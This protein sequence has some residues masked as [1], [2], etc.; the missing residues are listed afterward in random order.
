M[1]QSFIYSLFFHLE[2][3]AEVKVRG[4]KIENG[5]QGNRVGD[6]CFNNLF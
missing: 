4:R 5:E 2:V 6:C 1:N 3:K